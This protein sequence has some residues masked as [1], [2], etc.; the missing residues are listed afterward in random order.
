MKMTKKSS[1]LHGGEDNATPN[2]SSKNRDQ[3]LDPEAKLYGKNVTY[4]LHF[5]SFLPQLSRQMLR[6][7][8]S[9]DTLIAW[10]MC[11]CTYIKNQVEYDTSHKE[12]GQFLEE[13]RT[14]KAPPGHH[15][16]SMRIRIYHRHFHSHIT[17]PRTHEESKANVNAPG[18]Y[19]SMS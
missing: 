2:A 10:A 12:P 1:K 18:E 13:K 19:E 17:T 15:D 16:V 14:I 8:F 9:G 7:R 5:P 3:T 11:Q 6:R 4:C